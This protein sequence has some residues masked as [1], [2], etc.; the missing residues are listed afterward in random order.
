MKLLLDLNNTLVSNLQ[1]G[2][3]LQAISVSI[4]SVWQCDGVGVALPDADGKHLRFA[5]F[6]FPEGKMPEKMDE[7]KRIPRST[8]SR[9]S[10]AVFR[11]GEAH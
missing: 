5:A 11:T 2:D 8:A 4:R 1:L 9:K 6:D 3:L 10:R 7:H